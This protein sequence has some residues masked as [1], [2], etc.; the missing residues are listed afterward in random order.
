M[1]LAL[2]LLC[3]AERTPDAEAVVQGGTRF[4]YAELR[5]RAA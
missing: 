1:N 4:T 3:A 5:E 2:S